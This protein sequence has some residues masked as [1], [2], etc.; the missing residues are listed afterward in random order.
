MRLLG[1]AVSIVLHVGGTRI[2]A[3]WWT[4]I[5]VKDGPQIILP[6]P[7]QAYHSSLR[8]VG[9]IFLPLQSR[10]AL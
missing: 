5:V 8:G 9:S 6:L 1:Y 7:V 3:R 10:P 4:M 2:V